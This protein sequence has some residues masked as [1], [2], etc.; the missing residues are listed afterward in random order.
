MRWFSIYGLISLLRKCR[1]P[2]M[3]FT[4][5]REFN[6]VGL[7]RQKWKRCQNQS[8]LI[9]QWGILQSPFIQ[10][11]VLF[12][13]NQH[14]K[15]M[16]CHHTV[17]Q[18][19]YNTVKKVCKVFFVNFVWKY[20]LFWKHLRSFNHFYYDCPR[21]GNIEHDSAALKISQ[22]ICRYWFLRD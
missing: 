12:L 6:K 17:G 4:L 9:N 15:E 3:I 22:T 10:V 21:M 5:N 2:I 18:Q 16:S 19:Q 13:N 20:F 7:P 14:A 1:E 11:S 8:K